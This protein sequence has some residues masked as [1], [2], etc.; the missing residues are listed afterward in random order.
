MIYQ[1]TIGPN[2]TLRVELT[3]FGGE[4]PIA[5]VITDCTDPDNTCKAGL[6]VN[7][8]DFK[9]ALQYAPAAQETVK[10]VIDAPSS[11]VDEPFLAKMEVLPRQCTS[12]QTQCASD[13]QD[14]AVLHS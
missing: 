9:D 3:S 10:I 2:E 12:G 14:V 5:Y 13:G 6:T 11:G 4:A 7:G 1:A 8:G